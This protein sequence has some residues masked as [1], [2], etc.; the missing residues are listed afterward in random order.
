MIWSAISK[1]MTVS[2]IDERVA[3]EIPNFCIILATDSYKNY[4]DPLE[5][6][7][8]RLSQ[9]L[10]AFEDTPPSVLK[11]VFNDDFLRNA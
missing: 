4:K 11:V 7:T 1:L 5:K 3:V 9:T 10:S 2:L 8:Y 6:T